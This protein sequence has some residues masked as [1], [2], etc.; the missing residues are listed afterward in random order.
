LDV[1]ALRAAVDQLVDRHEMFRVSVIEVDG[2]PR[3]RLTD[4]RP[5]LQ[6]TSCATEA[7]PE[8]I[9]AISNRFD[10]AGEPLLRATLLNTSDGAT[11]VLAMPHLI[12]DGW[13]M[14]VIERDLDRAYHGRAFDTP[15][16]TTMRDHGAWAAE[17]LGDHDDPASLAYR[18][19]A[20]WS[21]RLAGLPAE[22]ALPT[23]HVRPEHATGRGDTV[24]VELDPALH[25]ATLEWVGGRQASLFMAVH[26]ALTLTLTRLGAG[27]DVAIGVSVAGRS[28]PATEHLVGFLANTVVLRADTSGH[29]DA[30]AMLQR[31]RT[32]AL[33]AMA[34]QDLPFATLV[35]R[36]RPPHAATNPYFRVMFSFDGTDSTER[37]MFGAPVRVEDVHTG[38]AKFDLTLYLR[39][40]LGSDGAPA[41]VRGFL[42]Y[43]TDLFVRSTAQAVAAALVR[44]VRSAVKPE[45]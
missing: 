23:D 1:T 33:G 2:E 18:H 24:S 12:C 45:V 7:I 29:P 15:P 28:E 11:F 6:V 35:G 25:R 17:V 8:R 40:Y 10:L 36:L 13:S 39:E 30:A 34:H 22:H 38:T 26:A 27:T 19:L 31:V 37:E 14:A 16:A 32:A 44:M 42:E 41:G 20:Y 4:R 5:A 43:S 9:R 3:M 21:D